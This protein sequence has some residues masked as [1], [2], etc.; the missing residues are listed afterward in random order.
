[1]SSTLLFLSEYRAETDCT[2]RHP[3]N[4]QIG[5]AMHTSYALLVVYSSYSVVLAWSPVAWCLAR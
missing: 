5:E 3:N 4:E 1:M 2:Q